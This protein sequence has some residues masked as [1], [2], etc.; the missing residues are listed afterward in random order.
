MLCKVRWFALLTHKIRT[1]V[2]NLWSGLFL[3]HS[4]ASCSFA[5]MDVL[6]R[7]LPVELS[8][9]MGSLN[10]NCIILIFVNLKVYKYAIGDSGLRIDSRVDLALC[11]F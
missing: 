1:V 7:L 6:A 10:V 5:E 11:R 9:A 2:C 8:S 4:L 3:L